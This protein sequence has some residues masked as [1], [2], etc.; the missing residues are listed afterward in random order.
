MNKPR[1]LIVEDDAEWQEIYRRCLSE[2]NYEIKSARKVKTALALLQEEIFDV[3]ITDLK[4]LGGNEEFSGFGVL[5]QAKARNPDIQV[6][7]ITGFGSADHALRAMGNGAYDYI[8]KDRDL[9]NKLSLTVQGALEVRLLKKELLEEKSQDDVQPGAN[10]IIGNSA[11]MQVLFEQITQAAENE[12]N[13]LIQG[14]GGTGKRLIAQTIHLRSQRRNGPFLVVDCGRLSETV[15]EAELF[16]YEAGTIYSAI[17]SHP[18]KFEEAQNGTIFL[19]GFG[20][21]D[22]ELQ[23]RLIG[24]ICDRQVERIGGKAPVAIDARIIASTDK[25]LQALSRQGRF[26]RKLFDVLGEYVITVPPLRKR[27]DGDDIPALV[28]MFIQ[29]HKKNLPVSITKE[30]IDLL[31]HYDYPGNV[32]EL[33]SIV[34]HLLSVARGTTILPEHLR[35]EVRGL[36]KSS[37]EQKDPSTILRVSPLNGGDCTKKDEILRL[38][39]P[40][41]VFVNVPYSSEF[42]EHEKVIRATLENYG[43]VPVVSKDHLEPGMLLC[44]ICKLLQTCK[45]GITDIS[46]AGTNVFYELGLMHAIGIHCAIL[47]DRRSSMMSD[48]GGMFYLEYTNPQS[49][50]EKLEL[51]IQGQVKEAITP[52]RAGIENVNTTQAASSGIERSNVYNIQGNAIIGTGKIV[53]RDDLSRSG[54]E[55]DD[56]IK[57]FNQLFAQID[58]LANLRQNDKDDLKDEITELQ[59][60]LAKKDQA[61]EALLMRR[62]RNIGRMAPDILEVTLATITN[63]IAGFGVIARKIAAKARSSSG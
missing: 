62:L 47:K 2:T 46:E 13:I 39:S 10:Q 5:E 30:T 37:G 4:M 8:T 12:I 42:A 29:R 11:S 22:I 25:D 27:K 53:G 24:A 49:L 20:D 32:R 23:P 35:P 59:K 60:E 19:D 16:G 63:P 14:E 21:L 44:N 36:S 7:V 33:E 58:S 17:E 41:R 26:E 48:I 18:G 45:Y 3:V 1:L 61:D 31:K 52:S 9:R 40:R 51:W 38:Y 50:K 55:S 28:A 15:L 6:I 56:V 34:K 43:L 57:L 54:L